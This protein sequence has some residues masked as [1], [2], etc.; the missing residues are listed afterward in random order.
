MHYYWLLLRLMN[1][2]TK[3]EAVERF[4]CSS[5]RVADCRDPYNPCSPLSGIREEASTVYSQRQPLP[6]HA[7]TSEVRLDFYSERV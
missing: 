2:A 5:C 6:I 7:P 3:L 4:C 1:A